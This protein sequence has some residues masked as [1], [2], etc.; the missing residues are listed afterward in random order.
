MWSDPNGD[1]SSTEDLDQ[2]IVTGYYSIQ[3]TDANDCIVTVDS[4]F[5]EGIIA[6]DPAPFYRN[7]K[8]YPVPVDD[9]LVIEIEKQLTEIMILGADGRLYKRILNPSSNKIDVGDLD[10]GWYILRMT[11]GENWYIARMVK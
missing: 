10:A 9:N 2:L 4:I 7:L 8:V 6:V 1:T 11:D 5:V 3:V